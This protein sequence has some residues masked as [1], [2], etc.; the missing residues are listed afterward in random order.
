MQD[1]VSCIWPSVLPALH[2]RPIVSV[3]NITLLALQ[4]NKICSIRYCNPWL[5]PQYFG[6]GARFLKVPNTFR[7]RIAI[8]K[9]PTHLFCKADLFIC[10]KRNKCQ[11]NCKVSCLEASSF[12]RYKDNYVTRNFLKRIG[13]LDKRPHCQELGWPC[14][15]ACFRKLWENAPVC[16]TCCIGCLPLGS[17]SDSCQFS[18]NSCCLAGTIAS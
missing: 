8:R 9:T 16:C 15:Q 3:D 17:S 5:F 10:C 6:P 11:N 14:E 4:A 1:V 7:V 13:T 2:W 18:A 12:R